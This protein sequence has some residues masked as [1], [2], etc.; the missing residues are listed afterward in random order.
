MGATIHIKRALLERG[1]SA[2]KLADMMEKPKQTLYNQMT[3]DSWKFSEVEKV[4][5]L[6]G[7][8]VAF[9]DRETGEK[10]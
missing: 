6:L 5:D 9:V 3:R 4:A 1:L 2:V 8:D 7:C 10:Y